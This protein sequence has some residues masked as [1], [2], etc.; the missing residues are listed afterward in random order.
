MTFP[1]TAKTLFWALFGLAPAEAPD[2]VIG[3]RYENGSIWHE[4]EYKEH[5]FTQGSGYVMFGMYQVIGVIILL[6]TLIAVMVI[7]FSNIPTKCGS[8]QKSK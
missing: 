6:N 2:V 3:N 7:F 5:K 8:L 1:S 4:Y